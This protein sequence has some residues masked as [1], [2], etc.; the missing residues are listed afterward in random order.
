M[1][2]PKFTAESKWNQFPEKRALEID[3]TAVRSNSREL[4]DAIRHRA[5]IAFVTVFGRLHVVIIIPHNPEDPAYLAYMK[6]K[7]ITFN[8]NSE[9]TQ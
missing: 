1:N 2:L 4:F 8:K 7:G 9:P 3:A 5:N 6:S